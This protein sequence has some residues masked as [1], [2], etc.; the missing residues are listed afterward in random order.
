MPRLKNVFLD[1]DGTVIVE[2]HYLCDPDQVEL[3]PGAGEALAALAARGLGLFLATNQSGVGRGYYG[4]EDFHAVQARLSS[5]LAPFGV[6]FTGVS[7][8]PHAPDEHC[9]CRKPAPGQFETQAALHGLDPAETV[10]VGDNV[11]D[12][13][14]G[15]NLGFAAAILVLTGHGREA[16]AKF[17]LPAP[18]APWR[19][20]A[21]RRPDQPHVLARDLPAAVAHILKRPANRGD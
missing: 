8:C 11:S 16:A 14:F 18:D 19:R 2:K 6:A 1:R 10:M 12:I 15:L 13:G 17:G 5:L 21:D 9:S 20:V 3:V 7:F 4:L